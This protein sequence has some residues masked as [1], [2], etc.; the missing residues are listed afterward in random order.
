MSISVRIP[1]ILRPYTG[2][3]SEVDADGDT[4]AA[5]L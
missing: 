1:T 4:L 2:G 3:S 5:V